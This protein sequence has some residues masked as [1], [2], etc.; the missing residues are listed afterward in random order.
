MSKISA[1]RLNALSIGAEEYNKKRAHILKV[2]GRVFK[3]VGYD[4]A[5]VDDIA[6][7]AGMNRA[8]LYYYFKGKSEIFREIVGEATKGNVEMAERIAGS[9]ATPR[10]KLRALVVELF[11]SYERHYPYM[12]AYLQEDMNRLEK[13]NSKWSKSIIKLNSRFN[14]AAAQIIE[15]GQRTGAFRKIGSPKLLTAGILGMCNWSHRWYRVDGKL[16]AREIAEV[17]ADMVLE[18]L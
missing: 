1:R 13:R 17:F 5:S 11:E 18:G 16:T 2:A 7:Q 12:Y 4:G 15:Q 8:S 6:K 14:V 3:Q 9:D 10:S